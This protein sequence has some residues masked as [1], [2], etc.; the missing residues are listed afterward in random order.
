MDAN[1]DARAALFAALDLA[2]VQRRVQ[3]ARTP[4][5][6]PRGV[7]FHLLVDGHGCGFQ[8][9]L[10]CSRTLAACIHAPGH[11]R[12]VGHEAVKAVRF[13]GHMV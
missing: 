5:W 12:N 1:G 10:S 11:A 9:A 8:N 7:G 4:A 3:I 6:I 13:K 2:D